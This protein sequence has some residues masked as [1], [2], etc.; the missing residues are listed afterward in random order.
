[1]DVPLDRL[2]GGQQR[3]AAGEQEI[4]DGLGDPGAEQH[5]LDASAVGHIDIIP[6]GCL[7]R[8]RKAGRP[9]GTNARAMREQ[10]GARHGG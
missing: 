1:M 9:L 10:D 4:L 6:G 3:R 8:D 5:S 2:D 7:A